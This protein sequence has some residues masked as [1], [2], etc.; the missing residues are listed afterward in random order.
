ME[1]ER[2]VFAGGC[3]WCT[4][5]AFLDMP[6]VQQVTSGYV[7]GHTENPTYEAVCSGTT[8]HYEAVEVVYDP[9]LI[10]YEKLLDI[11]W[12]S[13]DPTDA[14]GQFYDRGTQYKTAIFTD[15]ETQQQVAEKSK[16]RLNQSG[17]F[18]VPVVTE[19]RRSAPFWPAE[20]HHQKFCRTHPR[21]YAAYADSSGR[22]AALQRLWKKQR[23]A[24]RMGDLSPLQKKVAFEGGTEPPFNNEYWNTKEEGIY[25]DISTGQPLFASIHKY[26]SGTGWPSFFDTID[27][28][29]V[30]F[31]EE[32]QHGTKRCEIRSREGDI[33]L[34]HVFDD[35]PRPTQKRYC[36]NSA[37][38]RFIP[39]S[40]LSRHGYE[41]Y[42]YLF[43]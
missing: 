4:E 18:P 39:R 6:G 16:R 11:F 9:S 35:G 31:R 26:D 5:A 22:K 20:K 24:K 40:D 42:E 12:K 43:E 29:A 33:H 19:I 34:G 28:T 15:T 30:V 32:Y 3:F 21:R 1:H 10:P 2:A 27:D 17:V 14:G 37:S 25:V 23:R 8:G 7:G 41:Q 36:V 38:L 13:I